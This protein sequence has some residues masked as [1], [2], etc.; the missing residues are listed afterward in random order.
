MPRK[1]KVASMAQMDI[2]SISLTSTTNTR[3]PRNYS[4]QQQQ[5][6]PTSQVRPTIKLRTSGPIPTIGSIKNSNSSSGTLTSREP[7]QVVRVSNGGAGGNVSGGGRTIGSG[8]SVGRRM[9]AGGVGLGGQGVSTG[10]VQKEGSVTSSDD[11]TVSEDSVDD[12]I[13]LFSGAGGGGNGGLHVNSLPF[14]PSSSR[15]GS[16][17]SSSG[18][19][20]ASIKSRTKTVTT[21][22]TISAGTVT[23]SKPM[24]IAAGASIR[25]DG[26]SSSSTHAPIPSFPLSGSVGTGAGGGG[27]NAGSSTGLL[28]T[29]LS[30][31]TSSSSSSV[32]W[33]SS[34]SHRNGNVNGEDSSAATNVTPSTSAANNNNN[35]NHLPTSP[36]PQ[37]QGQPNIRTI[38]QSNSSVAAA[39]LAEENRRTEEA[40]RTRRKIADL[41][42]SNTSL[43]QVNQ[44][45]EATIRKQA[46]EMQ[47]LKMRIQSAQFGG[48]LSLLTSDLNLSQDLDPIMQIDGTAADSEAAVIIHEL[49]EAE[50][51]ADLTFRRL[52]ITIE[53]MIF[54]AKQA[55]DQST[56]K[57]GVKV[58]TSFDMYEKESTEDEEDELDAADQSI[59]LNEN[60]DDSK[61][62]LSKQDLLDHPCT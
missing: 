21:S 33:V 53:Q 25:V 1:A 7:S 18:P 48:D 44:T 54:E 59:V 9:G 61:E 31:S 23:A 28:S 51:K 34:P 38:K 8:S 62:A 52:C 37:G 4:Q 26:N 36:P 24:K 12:H 45:L 14:G 56:K 42:I 41:E 11:G 47:D 57:A 6:Q 20:V 40:A 30:S 60:E 27:A 10:R 29:S 22:S 32:S 39:K 50:R 19:K 16:L 2:S 58:L 17:G 13:Q 5:Q 43:L 49:T 35:N 15:Q 3:P 55:L 46:A